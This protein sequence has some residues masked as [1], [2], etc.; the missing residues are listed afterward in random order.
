MVKA[1][2]LVRF[3]TRND[4][5]NPLPWRVLT[6]QGVQDGVLQLGQ[7][8]ASEVRFTSPVVTT[9]DQIGPGV[10]KWHISASGFLSWNGDVCL[11]TDQ[12]P[13]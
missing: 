7:Q 10:F 1:Q 5:D 8:F 11:V 6:V 9:E 13:A 4:N 2:V 12:P 3:N